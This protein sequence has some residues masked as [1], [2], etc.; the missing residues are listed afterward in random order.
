MLSLLL[1]LVATP[2]AYS[3]FDDARAWLARRTGSAA[4][5]LNPD[6]TG[7]LPLDGS[8][9]ARPALPQLARN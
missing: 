1:T 8:A 2:V 5:N 3:L 9:P 6:E 7:E 4:G